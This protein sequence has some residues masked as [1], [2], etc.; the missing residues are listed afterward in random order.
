MQFF[1][2]WCLT[3]VLDTSSHNHQLTD[4]TYWK[5][6]IGRTV[7][8]TL[9]GAPLPLPPSLAFSASFI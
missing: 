6:L 4:H 8:K 5:Y 1:P 9:K 7:K 2:N 3:D